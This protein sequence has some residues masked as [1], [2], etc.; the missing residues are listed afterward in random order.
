MYKRLFL[1]M[2]FAAMLFAPAAA[3][4]AEPDMDNVRARVGKEPVP[5]YRAIIS[6]GGA[7]LE[8]RELIAANKYNGKTFL[9]FTL[10]PGAANLQISVPG[11]TIN[12]WSSTPS[13][14][15]DDHPS[16]GRRAKVEQQKVEIN[17]QLMTV[18][19]RIALWQAPPKN[20]NAQD[21]SQLQA[22]MAA[23]MPK[24]VLAQAE[25]QR[26]LKLVEEELSRMPR[27]SGI[28]ED[29][30]ILLEDDL[31]QGQKVE[32]RYNYTHD[33]CG[34]EAIYDFDALPQNGADIVKV[35]M[36]AE[37]W[38]FTG[39]DWKDTAIILA[40]KGFGPLE[41]AELPE[42]IVD[43][44]Q[45]RPQPRMLNAKAMPMAATAMGA[46]EESA[47]M[48]PPVLPNTESL[49]ASWQLRETG[50][51]QGR[52][53]LEILASEWKTP[54]Q[55]LARPSKRSSDVW[56]FAK[57]KLPGDQAWPVGQAQY[58]VNGESVG[59]SEFRPKGG[60]AT[61]YFGPDPRVTVLT[62][63]DA[64]KRG[65]SGIIKTSNNWTW[66]WTYTI[67]NQHQRPVMV[68]VERPAPI[69]VDKDVTVAY[70]DKPAAT[71]DS[72]KHMLMWDVE[73]PANGKRAIEHSLTISSPTSLPLLPDIP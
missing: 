69:I 68:K 2:I 14:L 56:I 59:T 24:L 20:G 19:A 25:L 47:D 7:R 64:Q 57:Y 62:T 51:P 61:L 58:S 34:W 29:V 15:S 67:V 72:K 45:P 9:L 38:Q 1:F 39:M 37:V 53:R 31:P 6:P 46:A 13:L 17:S 40:T 28:G 32:V 16:V 50:L 54:L 30:R 21:V 26:R 4:S 5:P 18:N 8:A 48:A 63:N 41:P 49:Y 60:E 42:W 43:S 70:H 73:V 3:I 11:H 44:Q 23:E 35:R 22:A 12:R 66:A 71:V 36:L 10:P 27:T 52:S 33:G 65:E 55:W